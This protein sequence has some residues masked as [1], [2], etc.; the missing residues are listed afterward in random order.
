MAPTSLD[1][2]TENVVFRL[3]SSRLDKSLKRFESESVQSVCVIPLGE[4]RRTDLVLGRLQNVDAICLRSPEQET[5]WQLMGRS[6]DRLRLYV[7]EGHRSA[8]A[9]H[10][11][12]QAAHVVFVADADS[13]AVGLDAIALAKGLHRDASLVLV[14]AASTSAPTKRPDWLP[15][16]Q[17]AQ[18]L[19]IRSE[20]QTDLER[21]LRL[22]THRAMGVELLP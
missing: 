16:F 9:R 22:V 11:I 8:W 3:P 4:S 15:R 6:T 20:N 19:H 17:A 5:Q 13:N 2:P 10:C 18:I 12:S 1:P 14:H 21:V 7:A